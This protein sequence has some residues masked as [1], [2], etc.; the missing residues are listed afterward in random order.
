MEKS[1]LTQFEQKKQTQITNPPNGEPMKDINFEEIMN[2]AKEMQDKFQQMQKEF[3]NKET[4]GLAGIKDTDKIFVEAT[5]DGS[6]ILKKLEVGEGVWQ[7]DPKIR[8]DL[9][10]AAINNATEKLNG[11]MQTEVKSLY[12]G[13]PNLTQDDA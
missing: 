13:A 11:Q 8:T 5:I 9:I 4:I 12:E 1:F 7:E 6:R 2:K 3:A 10:I